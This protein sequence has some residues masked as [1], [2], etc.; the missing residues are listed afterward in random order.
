VKDPSLIELLVHDDGITVP[1][2]DAIY[3]GRRVHD[4]SDLAGGRAL[5]DDGDKIRL[6]VFFRD[7]SRPCYDEIRRTRKVT[8]AERVTLLEKELDRYAV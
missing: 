6:G 7:E 4:P 3:K 1:E 5:A 8:A 2:L